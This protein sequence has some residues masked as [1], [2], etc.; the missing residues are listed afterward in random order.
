MQKHT[1]YLCPDPIKVLLM[2]SNHLKKYA[3]IFLLY[4]L[5]LPL[6]KIIFPPIGYFTWK[7]IVSLKK[8]KVILDQKDT[9][10]NNKMKKK[11]VFFLH[12]SVDRTSANS[13]NVVS[14]FPHLHTVHCAHTLAFVSQLGSCFLESAIKKIS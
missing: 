5:Q 12:Y 10:D 4:R 7:K 3:Y 13:P 6:A 1:R 2:L 14:L 11:K 8:I 9:N